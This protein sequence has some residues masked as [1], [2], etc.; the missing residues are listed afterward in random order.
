MK[1]YHTVHAENRN[2]DAEII[3]YST[4]GTLK[5]TPVGLK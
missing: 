4:E 3:S 5:L 1:L 2:T